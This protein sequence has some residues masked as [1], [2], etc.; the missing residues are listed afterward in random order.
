MYWCWGDS[1]QE[2]FP[3]QRP[4]DTHC[5][6]RNCLL[7]GTS[8][9]TKDNQIQEPVWWLRAR[10]IS[11]CPCNWPCPQAR[12]YSWI[13]SLN[14]FFLQKFLGGLEFVLMQNR[15][16]SPKFKK[17]FR[18]EKPVSPPALFPEVI[19]ST[20]IGDFWGKDRKEHHCWI[21]LLTICLRTSIN[22]SIPDQC[23]INASRSKHWRNCSVLS[24]SV[25]HHQYQITLSSGLVCLKDWLKNS[26]KILL[27]AISPLISKEPFSLHICSPSHGV[28]SSS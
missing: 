1:H 22:A 15:K 18:N 4:R 13:G 27:V 14:L 2:R 21:L 9:G 3:Q 12:Y 20:R 19:D 6:V 5:G 11:Q 26:Q 25:T 23:L 8:S 10:G 7:P 16:K 17:I 28:L 24:C